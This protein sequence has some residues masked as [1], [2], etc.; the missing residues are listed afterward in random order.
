MLIQRLFRGSFLPVL[1]PY[2]LTAASASGT[3]EPSVSKQ[4]IGPLPPAKVIN[5]KSTSIGVARSSCLTLNDGAIIH[6]L[7]VG[8][9]KHK[10]SIQ[11]ESGSFP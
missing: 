5:D 11:L 10:S 4:R 8:M 9:E 1:V 7:F 3:D 2:S 6:G